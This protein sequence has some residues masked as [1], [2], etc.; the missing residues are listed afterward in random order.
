MLKFCLKCHQEMDTNSDTCP[1]CRSPLGVMQE[2]GAY[3]FRATTVAVEV[4]AMEKAELICSIPVGMVATSDDIQAFFCRKYNADRVSFVPPSPLFAKR[5]GDKL[6]PVM[7]PEGGEELI[8]TWRVVSQRGCVDV[9][10]ADKL[11]EEGHEIIEG[12]SIRVA[13][14]KEKLYSFA[15]KLTE[16]KQGRPEWL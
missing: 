15:N 4:P 14:Y 11:R 10:N 5:V 13:D 1:R 16:V 7:W 2:N 3:Y 9:L 6:I 12:R 8:P